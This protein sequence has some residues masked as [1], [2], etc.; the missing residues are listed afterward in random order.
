MAGIATAKRCSRSPATTATA[1]H[2]GASG[3]GGLDLAQL[4]PV[5]AYLHL[6]LGI[7][8][9]EELQDG[10]WQVAASVPVRYQ[11][12]RPRRRR[13]PS[14]R[15]A[16]IPVGQAPRRSTARRAPSRGSRGRP[17]PRRGRTGW[18]G[19]AVGIELHDGS[20]SPTSK[21][22]RPYAGLGRAAHGHEQHPSAASSADPAAP[23]R[24]RRGPDRRPAAARAV[25]EHHVQQGGAS[26]TPSRPGTSELAPRRCV[27]ALLLVGQHDGGSERDREDVERGEVEVK[28]DTPRADLPAMPIGA[29]HRRW[30]STRRR[31][32]PPTPS[33]PRWS[34]TCRSRRP[35][36]ARRASGR[37]RGRPPRGRA[38]S[39]ES[40]HRDAPACSR[41]SA[42]RACG[43]GDADGD[44]RRPAAGAPARLPPGQLREPDG[45]AVALAHAGGGEPPGDAQGAAG[46][47]PVGRL[48]VGSPPQR[49]GIRLGLGAGE[50][51]SV[52]RPAAE[53]GPSEFASARAARCEGGSRSGTAPTSL[54]PPKRRRPSSTHRTYRRSFRR[55]Q[56]GH[57]SPTRA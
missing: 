15:I 25:V 27:A 16:Q 39:V 20:T 3:H 55:E 57:V 10:S 34:R 38:S 53:V 44:V 42:A 11:R 31:G 5:A 6:L 54:R 12:P 50:E 43:L 48:A 1:L 7:L 45:H 14:S 17:R 18:R 49:R 9:T 47:L 32:S 29:R 37:G 35:A 21:Y 41:M 22:V 24:R 26:S 13:R 2:P 28:A 8:A 23:G 56:L 40:T 36:R 30:C 33:A 4:H 19:S 46:K 51:P 52:E